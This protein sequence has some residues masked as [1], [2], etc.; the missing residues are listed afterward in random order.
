MP[1]DQIIKIQV[2]RYSY[3][4]MEITALKVHKI[5]GVGAILLHQMQELRG[6]ESRA[7]IRGFYKPAVAEITGG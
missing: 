7:V 4:L 2:V 6:G 3:R 1:A 5:L